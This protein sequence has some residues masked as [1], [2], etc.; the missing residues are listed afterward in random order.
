MP[1]ECCWSLCKDAM[2]LIPNLFY[3]IYVNKRM[4]IH[5]INQDEATQIGYLYPPLYPGEKSAD[6]VL[7]I[8]CLATFL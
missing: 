8:W 7:H 5:Q 1:S 6:W 2:V 4:D 3:I